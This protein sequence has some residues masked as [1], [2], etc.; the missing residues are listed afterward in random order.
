M[1]FSNDIMKINFKMFKTE[2]NLKK[3][4]QGLHIIIMLF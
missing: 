4:A 3:M 1:I 2:R